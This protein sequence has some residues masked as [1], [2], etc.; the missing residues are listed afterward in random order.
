MA[1]SSAGSILTAIGVCW[2]GAVLLTLITSAVFPQ[3]R[4]FVSSVS[5]TTYLALWFTA[6]MPGLVLV[7][8]GE[9]MQQQ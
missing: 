9:R 7:L 3:L 8:L 1:S 6:V 2:P 5:I 4:D